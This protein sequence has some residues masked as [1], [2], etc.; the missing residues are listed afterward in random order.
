VAC[1]VDPLP[2]ILCW[3]ESER[4][5]LWFSGAHFRA[6]PAFYL[7]VTLRHVDVSLRC[8]AFEGGTRTAAFVA[9][10]LIP[11]SLRGSVNTK[12]LSHITDW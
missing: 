8:T 5:Q 1:S 6:I 3:A 11:T 12:L 4:W 7:S 9:G 10:G 2:I